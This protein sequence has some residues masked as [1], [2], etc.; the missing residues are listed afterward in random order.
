MSTMGDHQTGD[1]ETQEVHD[2]PV[3]GEGGPF[4]DLA[5]ICAD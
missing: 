5:Y 4:E 3:G 1:K 2:G